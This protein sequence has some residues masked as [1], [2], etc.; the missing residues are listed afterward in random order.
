M[1]TEELLEVFSVWSAARLY[2]EYLW[3]KL[4]SWRSEL[5]VILMSCKSVVAV[6]S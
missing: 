3:E 5:T 4:V 6:Y 1:T 2:S